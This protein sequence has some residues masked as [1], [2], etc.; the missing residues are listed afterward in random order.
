MG[1]VYEARIIASSTGSGIQLYDFIEITIGDSGIASD[2]PGDIGIADDPAVIFVED[3]EE[4]TLDDMYANWDEAKNSY[5]MS[6]S[7]DIP[8]DSGGSQSLKVTHIGEADTGAHL[9]RRLLPGYDKLYV[10]FYT[11]FAPDCGK[12]HH[13]FHFGG[14][15]P[16]TTWP[17]GGA[18]V[19]PAGD[20]RFTT[21]IEPFGDNWRW[22]FYSYW[23]EMHDCP[24]G[25]F[26]G[27]DFINDPDLAVNKGEWTCLELMMQMNDPVTSS[28]GEMALW[29]D[30]QLR[31][32]D[33]Q[34][35]S[36]L[37]EGFP[38]GGWVWDSWH[39]D[40]AGEPFGGFRWRMDEDLKLNFL[41]LLVYITATPEG[42]I[43]ELWYDQVVV[44][45]EYIGPIAPG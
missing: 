35:V 19:Q 27:N 33:G 36:Y 31:A 20:E 1:G 44:A 26:W 22:D 39:P 42:Y 40:L 4:A 17:K 2:Y 43:S 7:G 5:N 45:T 34:V 23:M 14:Y 3:F 30:G 32:K 38:N 15:N 6:F 28:N 9:Y 13:F 10:R 37:G 8:A 11:K 29:I 25:D 24:T 16:P 18:G 12:I 41:W 21:G